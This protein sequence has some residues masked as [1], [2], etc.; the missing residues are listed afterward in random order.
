MRGAIRSLRYGEVGCFYKTAQMSL[1]GC[2]AEKV[3]LLR[4][5]FTDEK[6]GMTK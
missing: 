2:K 3:S 6:P 1:L 5:E 4:W